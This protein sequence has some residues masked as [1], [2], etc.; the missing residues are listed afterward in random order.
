MQTKDDIIEKVYTDP[1]GF[2]S[3]K[4]TF[5]DAYKIDKSIT[6]EDV[7]LWIDKNTQRKTNLKGYNSYVSPGPNHEYQIDLFFMSD[8][9]NE[10]H[11]KYKLAM[12]AIDAFTR[13]LTVV[14]LKGKNEANFL[15][16][17]MECFKNLGGKPKV[18]YA[19]QE[20]SFNGKYVQQYLKE[21][22][23]QLIMTLAH[24]AIVERAIG[25][26]KNMLYK[27]LEHDPTR[28]W[29]GDL[30]QQVIFTYNYMRP[31]ST[32]GLTPNEARQP[33]NESEVRVNLYKKAKRNRVYPTIDIGDT[34]RIYQK[35]DKLSKQQTSVWTKQRY[36]VE[37][38]IVDKDQTFYKTSYNKGKML[39]RHELL[40]IP[41]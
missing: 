32:V 35:K 10:E 4:N 26:I 12:C 33:K 15:A 11:Q 23:I 30:L 29:Y 25:T 39:L 7:K 13:F 38:I 2:G 19:D 14:P 21:N 36:T 22:D 24:A 6:I 28:P 34:V 37:D 8:L 41:R 31:H 17:L 5:N 20:G 3:I 18:I 1:S 9:K 16:G 40:K 27:R